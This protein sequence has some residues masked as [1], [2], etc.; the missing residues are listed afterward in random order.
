[1]PVFGD[2]GVTDVLIFIGLSVLNMLMFFF[3]KLSF[4]PLFTKHYHYLLARSVSTAC[5]TSTSKRTLARIVPL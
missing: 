4:I 5:S 2:V 1:M 3:G